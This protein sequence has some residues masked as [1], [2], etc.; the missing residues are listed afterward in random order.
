M[1]AIEGD[2]NMATRS[3]NNLYHVPADQWEKWT[4]EAR[5]AFNYLYSLMRANQSLFKH[6]KAPADTRAHWN[7]TAWNV[8]WEAADH[9]TD[10]EK[11]R[12]DMK[13]RGARITDVH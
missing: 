6:P 4:V 8:A 1:R 7:T 9:H 13:A 10:H 5:E 12:R 3:R 2:R 11:A